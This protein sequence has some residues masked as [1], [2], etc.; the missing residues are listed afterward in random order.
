MDGLN[1]SLSDPIGWAAESILATVI[2]LGEPCKISE[3]AGMYYA[4]KGFIEAAFDEEGIPM[5]TIRK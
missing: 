2:E 3:V 5:P 1:E 4:E